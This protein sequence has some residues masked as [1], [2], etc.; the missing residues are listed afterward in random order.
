[1]NSKTLLIALIVMMGGIVI[2]GWKVMFAPNAG[3]ASGGNS[4]ISLS[5][6]PDPLR[7]GQ[8]IFIIDVRDKDNKPVDNATVSYDLNMATMN[9]GTQQ[10]NAIPQG[11]GQYSATGRI[12]MQGPWRVRTTVK[13]PD[14]SIENKDFTVNVPII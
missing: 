14:G 12:S 3:S 6:N 5:T 9:M 10:G 8:A 4:A 2:L 13:M 7:L 11:N 1:M